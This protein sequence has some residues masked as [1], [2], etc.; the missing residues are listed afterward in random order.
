MQQPPGREKW[1][2]EEAREVPKS[3]SHSSR[4]EECP[5]AA[6]NTG[7]GWGSPS[8]DSDSGRGWIQKGAPTICSESQ[9]GCRAAG[10]P[11]KI[12]ALQRTISTCGEWAG[13]VYRQGATPPTPIKS[14]MQAGRWGGEEQKKRNDSVW[15]EGGG[16][17]AWVK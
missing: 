14:K 4:T 5:P 13:E 12:S 11:R 15:E 7:K 3:R 1:E 8:E 6:M 2:L 17:T 9:S 16:L 10:K